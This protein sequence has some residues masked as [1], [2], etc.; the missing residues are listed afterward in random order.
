MINLIYFILEL[1]W[2]STIRYRY[3]IDYHVIL[4]DNS[5]MVV[6]D[7]EVGDEIKKFIFISKQIVYSRIDRC[8]KRKVRVYRVEVVDSIIDGNG[9]SKIYIIPELC[10]GIFHKTK[11]PHACAVNCIIKKFIKGT[12]N[13]T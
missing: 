11:V 2:N 4:T 3:P 12:S 5:H 9:K 10:S 8:T 13:D 6:T 1:F 7:V